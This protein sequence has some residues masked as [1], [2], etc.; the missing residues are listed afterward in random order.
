MFIDG[1]QL[2]VVP[3]LFELDLCQLR[4]FFREACFP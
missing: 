1:V 3:Y 2:E 4:E